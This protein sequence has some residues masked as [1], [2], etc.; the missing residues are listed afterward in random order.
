MPDPLPVFAW[1]S[2]ARSSNRRKAKKLYNSLTWLGDPADA[3][4]G[5]S[6]GNWSAWVE[7]LTPRE[8]IDSIIYARLREGGATSFA[9]EEAATRAVESLICRSIDRGSMTLDAPD[10]GATITR[11]GTYIPSAVEL[12]EEGQ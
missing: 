3:F 1:S 2:L 7:V 8:A 11:S 12:G 5:G 6:S 9:N 10:P 4:V